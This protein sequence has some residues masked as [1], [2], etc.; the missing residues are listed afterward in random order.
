VSYADLEKARQCHAA[1]REIFIHHPGGWADK[2]ALYKVEKLAWQA[3]T[4]VKDAQ[5]QE[6]M[7]IVEHYAA[8]LYSEAEHHKWRMGSLPGSDFL[9]LQILRALVAFNGRLLAI[10]AARRNGIDPDQPP[11]RGDAASSDPTPAERNP[12]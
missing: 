6:K 4:A 12:D 5:C 1:L 11:L 10:E 3:M 8:A 2:E 7:G 9:R